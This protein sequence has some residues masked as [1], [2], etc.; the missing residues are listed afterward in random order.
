MDYDRAEDTFLEA[1]AIEPK[2]EEPY[3]SLANLYLDTGERAKAKE[4]IA[5][6]KKTLPEEEQKEIEKLE[7]E[8]KGELDGEGTVFVLSLIHI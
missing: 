5:E 2:K 6:A 1:I 3:V 7:E 8:R 4:I